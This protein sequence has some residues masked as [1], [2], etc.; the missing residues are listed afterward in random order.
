MDFDDLLELFRA[1][2]R[3]RVDCVLV[4]GIALSI[5]GLVRATEAI[6][7]FVRPEAGNAER[8]KLALRSVRD[9]PEIERISREDLA[10]EYATV[11]YV[12]PAG[13]PVVDLLSRLGTAISDDDLEAETVPFEG[14]TCAWPPPACC[15]G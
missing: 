7:L 1:L 2:E 3:H 14:V 15:T 10:G 11:R 4:G 9:D 12:P 8:L 5:H 13:S 6:D